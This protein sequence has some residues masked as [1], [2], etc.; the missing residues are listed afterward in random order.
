SWDRHME[1]NLHAPFVLTQQFA[2]AL[3]ADAEGNV[4]NLLDQ[5]VWNLTGEFVTY[6]LSKS[7]LWTL[8]RTLALALAPRVRVN[9]VGPGPVLPSARQ[10]DAHF[11]AQAA[12]TPL[13]RPVDV[14]DVVAA[15]RF[16]I[17]NRAVTGQMIAVDSGQHLVTPGPVPE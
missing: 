4:I 12:A 3:A 16:L 15:V 5:R 1:V 17:A 11:A 10:S 14:A 2:R 7:A 8:T 9:G 6:T 13:G